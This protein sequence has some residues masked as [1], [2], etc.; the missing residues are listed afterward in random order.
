[1]YL[2]F[3]FNSAVLAHRLMGK[4]LA[5]ITA[6][7]IYTFVLCA[8]KLRA[9]GIAVSLSAGRAVMTTRFHRLVVMTGVV[10]QSKHRFNIV[11]VVVLAQLIT[12]LGLIPKLS[13]GHSN[14][15]STTEVLC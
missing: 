12:K 13:C 2:F 3:V 8:Q 5:A 4:I 10:S 9:N 15:C 14:T 1:M 11:T 7:M 6:N